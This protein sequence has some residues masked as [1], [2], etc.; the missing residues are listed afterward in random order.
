MRQRESWGHSPTQPHPSSSHPEGR[1]H[2]GTVPAWHTGHGTRTRWGN[3]RPKPQLPQL[4]EGTSLPC[5]APLLVTSPCPSSLLCLGTTPGQGWLG[6]SKAAAW[7]RPGQTQARYNEGQE[8]YLCRA[9]WA[10]T[11]HPKTASC[12][13][14]AAR[15]PANT[16]RASEHGRWGTQCHVATACWGSEAGRVPVVLRPGLPGVCSNLSLRGRCQAMGRDGGRG[17]GMPVPLPSPHS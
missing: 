13:P 3:D 9:P 17:T 14:T 8:L 12:S 5:V 2:Q 6:G 10:D 4:G 15:P 7:G 1:L 16:P 11:L